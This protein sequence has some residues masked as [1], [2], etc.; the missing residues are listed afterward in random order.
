VISLGGALDVATGQ[1]PMS[2]TEAAAYKEA[3]QTATATFLDRSRSRQE[4][5]EAA[6]KL[7]YPDDATFAA[8]LAIGVDQKEDDAI[9][10]EALRRH[11]YDDKYVAAVLKILSDPDDGGEELDSSLIEDISRRTT[12]RIPTELRQRIQAVFRSLL[13]DR[14]PRVRLHAYRAAVAAHD[15]VAV[16]RLADSLRLGTNVPIPV[17]EAIDLLDQDGPLNHIATLRP[18]LTNR[19]PQVQARA[20][21]ALAGD[22]E[23][24]PA[25]VA[26]ARDANTPEEVRVSA[27]RAL[28][29]EDAEFPAY[30]IPLL[31]D[32]RTSTRVREAAMKTVVGRMNYHAVSPADQIR[33]AQAVER[34]ATSPQ[35]MA[36]EAENLRESARQVQRYIRQS[37]PDVQK[38][39][40]TR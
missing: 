20:T 4:R 7:G 30:A 38:Y 36:I 32:P 35:I 19:D 33:F 26:L 18:Y 1:T 34:I 25:I 28:S 16:N 6:K 29:R 40:E 12:F 22:R 27:L 21:R 2:A 14:R 11:R 37:F 13:D 3:K 8:L 39:Y 10:A 31:E 15:P 17:V 9:R 5:L 24:R 23:S